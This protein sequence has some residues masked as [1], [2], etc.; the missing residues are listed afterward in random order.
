M[1]QSDIFLWV[2]TVHSSTASV[3]VR[4]LMITVEVLRGDARYELH[5]QHVEAGIIK[6]VL[7]LHVVLDNSAK[8]CSI[9]A[10]KKADKILFDKWSIAGTM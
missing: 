10:M 8:A 6:S 1:I 3:T 7:S 2:G 4:I 5:Q 9:M